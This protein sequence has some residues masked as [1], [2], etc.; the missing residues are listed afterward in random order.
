MCLLVSVF[1]CSVG[2]FFALLMLFFAAKAV[3]LM[4]LFVYLFFCSF[5][6]T[7][8]SK[9]IFLG[10]IFESLLPM[11]SSGSFMVLGLTFKSVTHFEF[12]FVYGIRM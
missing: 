1:T 3:S 4:V 2:F 6:Q 9:K 8:I 12:V 5:A 11:F 10:T 7:D